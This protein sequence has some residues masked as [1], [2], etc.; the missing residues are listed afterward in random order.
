M[1]DPAQRVFTAHPRCKNLKLTSSYNSYKTKKNFTGFY[2]EVNPFS[3][4]GFTACSGG[5]RVKIL[6]NGEEGKKRVSMGLT[7]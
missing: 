4:S 6:T 1:V 3:Q 5:E 2:T 7:V